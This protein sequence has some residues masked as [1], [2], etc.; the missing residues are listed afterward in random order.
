MI[1]SDGGRYD[2]D[3]LDNNWNGFGQ[4]YNVNKQL[5]IGE[6]KNGSAGVE[7]FF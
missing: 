5:F 3:W 7:E 1:Y 6:F 2:G 4:F